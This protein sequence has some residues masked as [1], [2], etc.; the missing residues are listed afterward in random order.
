MIVATVL[1][2]VFDISADFLDATVVLMQNCLTEKGQT[3][4]QVTQEAIDL[5]GET[6][7]LSPGLGLDQVYDFSLLDN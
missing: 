3:T 7:G 4:A 1:Q 5:M 2:E 6:L